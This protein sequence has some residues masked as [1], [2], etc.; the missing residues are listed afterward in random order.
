[1]ASADAWQTSIDICWW[2]TT[3]TGA[4]VGCCHS[5]PVNSGAPGAERKS[6]APRTAAR[7]ELRHKPEIGDLIP[8]RQR[9]EKQANLKPWKPVTQARLVFYRV[10]THSSYLETNRSSL[11]LRKIPTMRVTRSHSLSLT[12]M[13]AQISLTCGG[14]GRADEELLIDWLN[15]YNCTV[16]IY[17]I[18]Y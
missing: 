5:F 2:Q 18:C 17:K 10:K 4:T 13:K 12:P 6:S 15:V 14:R 3:W 7:A 1:M 9:R 8:K 11:R 16:Q